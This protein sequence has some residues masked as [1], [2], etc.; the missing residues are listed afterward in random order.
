[1]KK[2][3]SVICALLLVALAFAGCS[4]D[5]KNNDKRIVCTMFPQYDW[6]MEILG[7]EAKEWNVELLMQTGTD[8]HSFEPT[9]EDIII[10]DRSDL[11][12]HV[13][14]ESDE[15]VDDVLG[16]SENV[17][18]VINMLETLGDDAIMSEH[19]HDHGHEHEHEHEEEE[20]EHEHHDEHVWL[21]LHNAE[22]LCDVICD[23]ICEIDKDNEEIYRANSEKYI[24]KINALDEKYH[25]TVEN[26][27]TNKLLFADR[28]PFAYMVDD[29]GLEYHAAFSGCS[30]ESNATSETIDTLISKLNEWDLD[31]VIVLEGSDKEIAETVIKGSRD[32]D[33]D[34][35]V[36]NSL[37]SVTIVDI[38][39]GADY[40]E[41]MEKNLDALNDALN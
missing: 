8:L 36:L 10:I 20:E 22:L 37:Q 5:K 1:M 13:G 16:Q 6:V 28:F 18:T 24:N 2:T 38:E 34:I 26:A 12:I 21:S 32:K 39:K 40:I 31:S 30:T 15:W 14:G 4:G 29:Y 17:G 3:I 25:D 7:E 33:Q 41:L 23:S 9:A 35:I 11:F 27:K 19:E